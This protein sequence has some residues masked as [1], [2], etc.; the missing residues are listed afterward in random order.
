VIHAEGRF[1]GADGLELY[2]QSWR[3][4]SA[5]RAVVTLV[6]G[7]CEHSGRYGNVVGRLVEDGYAV[8]GYDLRGHGASPGP[9]VHIGRWAEYREDLGACLGLVAEQVP[10]R[11]IVVY[12]HSMGA[13]VV[14]DYLLQRPQ[15]LAGAIVS[16][17]PIEPS[18]VATPYLVAVARIL[19]RVLPRVSVDLGLDAASLSRDLE[20]VEAYR[21]DRMVTSRATVRWGT[22]S[23]AAVRRI[24]QG[25]HGIDVPLLVLHGEADRLHSIEGSWAL[26][27]AVS[28]PDKKLRV[29]PGVYHEPH[30]DVGHEQVLADITEWLGRITGDGATAP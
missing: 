22:E 16:S 3:P 18:G 6:H 8:Y 28:H 21:A 9:R 15:G 24:K 5:P 19:S 1:R 29:Y 25:M 26:F 30:N 2:Y 14:L 7:V 20:V 23:L 11:P 4:E 27:E 17:P 10:G 13:L 12:G